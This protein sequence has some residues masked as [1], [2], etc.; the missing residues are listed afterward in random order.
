MKLRV[1]YINTS[2][3]IITVNE[4]WLIP[5]EYKKDKRWKKQPKE[6]FKRTADNNFFTII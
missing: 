2:Y 3:K 4:I 1:R 6:L 5:E